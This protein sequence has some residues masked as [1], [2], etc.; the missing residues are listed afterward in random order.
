MRRA[1]RRD[2]NHGEI[3]QAFERLGCWVGD[4]SLAGDGWPDL[5]CYSR[6]GKKYFLVECK[7]EHGDLNEKQEKFHAACPGTISIV[8]DVAGVET[9]VRAMRG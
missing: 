8:R 4:L 7:T 6:Q 5:L 1:T 3:K 2:K 9:I